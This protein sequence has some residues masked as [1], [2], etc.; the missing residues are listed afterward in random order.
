MR[1]V[2][3]QIIA[4]VQMKN[5]T[6]PPNEPYPKWSD[7]ITNPMNRVMN[8][9][10]QILI[11]FTVHVKILFGLFCR[12]CFFRSIHK[13]ITRSPIR[14]NVTTALITINICNLDGIFLTVNK[15]MTSSR[16]R[17]KHMAITR[18]F[19]MMNIDFFIGL[20]AS[21]TFSSSNVFESIDI[22][23]KENFSI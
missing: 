19:L 23:L 16:K 17:S 2:N 13:L 3:I 7:L 9:N 6:N 15:K 20:I 11:K 4:N 21:S 8:I 12:L 14:I 5:R 1:R 10:K 22:T 18:T